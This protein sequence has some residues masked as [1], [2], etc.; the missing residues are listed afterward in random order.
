MRLVPTAI[1]QLIGAVGSAVIYVFPLRRCA[2]CERWLWRWKL[3][4]RT[5]PGWRMTILDSLPGKLP[6]APDRALFCAE[7]DDL[8]KLDEITEEKRVRAKLDDFMTS[9][10][11]K[12]DASRTIGSRAKLVPH[13]TRKR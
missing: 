11:W 4:E 8:N 6:P 5:R 12:R 2:R 7:C 1:D 13:L 9:D 3:I 10:E